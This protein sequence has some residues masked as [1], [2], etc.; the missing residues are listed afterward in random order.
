MIHGYRRNL[1]F[2]HG[3]NADPTRFI[4]IFLPHYFSP[5]SSD[6]SYCFMKNVIWNVNKG[7]GTKSGSNEQASH[8]AGILIVITD[9]VNSA[10]PDFFSL[11]LSLTCSDHNDIYGLNLLNNCIREYFIENV[12]DKVTE[13][14]YQGEKMLMIA[15]GLLKCV[16]WGFFEWQEGCWSSLEIHF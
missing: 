2:W 11:K 7:F 14:P 1:S 3:S 10:C 13:E 8:I 6:R 9:K 16:K 4:K 5:L 15:P 12:I